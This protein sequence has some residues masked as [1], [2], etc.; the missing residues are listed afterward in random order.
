MWDA[1]SH[2]KYLIGCLVAL[3]MGRNGPKITL[4]LQKILPFYCT[5]MA[6]GSLLTHSFGPKW[7]LGTCL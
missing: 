7:S 6:F 2:P 5:F 1:P 3:I 4:D